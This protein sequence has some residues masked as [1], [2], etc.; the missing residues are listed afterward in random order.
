MLQLTDQS[1]HVRTYAKPEAALNRFVD[2]WKRCMFEDSTE[3]LREE[4]VA[5]HTWLV[6]AIE[7]LENT[8]KTKDASTQE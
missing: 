4:R 8:K 7:C 3:A 6:E 5:L 2:L 1:G